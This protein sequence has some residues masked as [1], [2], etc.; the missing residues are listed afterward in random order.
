LRGA[1]ARLHSSN[2][3]RAECWPLSLLTTNTHDTK[4]S[5]DVRARLDALTELEHDWERAVRRWRRLN[6]KHRRVVDGRM[7]PDTNTEYLMYQTIVALW[8]PPRPGRRTDDLPDRA[9]REGARERLATY[10]IKAAREAKTRTSWVQPNAAY[11]AAL[12]DFVRRIL[13]PGDDAPFLPDV[14]RLVSL[15]APIGV[16]NSLSR[17]AIHLTAPGVPDIYQGDELW[18]FALVDPDNRRPVDFDARRRTLPDTEVLEEPVDPVGN[19]LKAFVTRRLLVL[20]R[21]VPNLFTSGGYIPL[22]VTGEQASHIVAFARTEGDRCALTV[23]SRATGSIPDRE[24]TQW[25]RDTAI[26]LPQNI[27]GQDLA[28]QFTRRRL[29]ASDRAI[30]AAD[31]LEKLP[32]TVLVN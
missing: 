20:R 28:C 27:D 10:A 2:A 30:R 4:R 1:V 31:A 21:S 3:H 13:E 8:P 5:A 24:S 9:W 23:V 17:I 32:V 26:I 19:R 7:S 25:W 15:A 14:A 22:E 16:S 12:C 18:N 29:R 11:E 6:A